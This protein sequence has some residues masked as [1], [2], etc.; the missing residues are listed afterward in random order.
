MYDYLASK[1][2]SPGVHA[3]PVD[4]SLDHDKS[5]KEYNKTLKI[6][7][8]ICTCAV[9]RAPT[10]DACPKSQGHAGLH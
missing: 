5:T 10:L 4:S 1:C 6:F 3:S 2:L 9:L 7:A 8:N